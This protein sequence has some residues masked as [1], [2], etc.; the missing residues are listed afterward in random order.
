MKFFFQG[1]YYCGVGAGRIFGRDIVEAHY[2]ACLFAGVNISGVNSEVAPG[3]FEYQVGPCEGID[4]G[5]HLW[6][7]RYILERVGED[8]AVSVT[9]HPKP[10]QGDWNGAGCHTSKFI[11]TF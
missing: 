8:F 11:K 4:M 3:Q 2:R 6:I 9:I 10:V 7:A 5:D 1:K